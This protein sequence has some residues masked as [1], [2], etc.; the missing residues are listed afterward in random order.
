M[1]KVNW[2][3]CLLATAGG[4]DEDEDFHGDEETRE[5]EVGL[6]RAPEPDRLN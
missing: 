4:P 2:K 3:R 5:R 6:D 1:A